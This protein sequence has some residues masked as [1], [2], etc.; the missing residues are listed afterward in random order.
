M[1][2]LLST[3][4]SPRAA[5]IQG[6][7]RGIGLE[8]A[9]QLVEQHDFDTVIATSRY[10]EK[11]DGLRALE[12]QHLDHVH[13]VALDV[14]DE[15]SIEAAREEVGAIVDS[16]DLIYNVAGVLHDE[17]TGLAP[18]KSLRDVEPSNF[19]QS[20]AVNATG[21]ALVAK[22]FADLLPRNEPAVLANMSAR[23]G[24]VGDNHKGGWYAYRA[25]K[26]AQNQITRTLSI[27]L[28]R[29][30][31]QTVC[32]ALHPGT[33]DTNLSKPFQDRVPEDQ[34]FSVERAAEQLLDVIDGL[35]QND[36][37]QFFDWAGEPVEW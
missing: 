8:I 35:D 1:S 4:S 20:F 6:A 7:S 37:G 24:S 12:D 36:T 19:S 14:T 23:V 28:G 18:E 13:K 26:A 16:L 11:S 17:T 34:L 15:S 5:L 33:V 9:R 29:R 2:N 3:M 32:V 27:E 10:P 25:A 30:Y 31:K 22:Y 21:P